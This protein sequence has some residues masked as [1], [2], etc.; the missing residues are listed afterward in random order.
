MPCVAHDKRGGLVIKGIVSS[1]GVAL[2]LY[3]GHFAALPVLAF[4]ALLWVLES[5]RWERELFRYAYVAGGA[6]ALWC[7]AGT[8]LGGRSAMDWLIEG[9]L[10]AIPPAWLWAKPQSAIAVVACVCFFL[11]EFATSC[12]SLGDARVGSTAHKILVVHVTLK[13]IV[14]VALVEGFLR[15]RR[16]RR[17]GTS[18]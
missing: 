17:V 4:A 13:G 10:A 6:Y 2:W 8:V 16:S 14:L 3:A 11:W 12:I 18:G 15:V 1:I 5:T 7:L 9:S